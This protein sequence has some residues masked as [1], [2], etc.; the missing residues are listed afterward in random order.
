[1]LQEE[2][3]KRIKDF[4]QK[5]GITQNDL[6]NALYIS[7]QAISKW[8]RG[9]NLPDIVHLPTLANI[10][11]ISIDRLLGHDFEVKK[12]VYGSIFFSDIQGF[13]KLSGVLSPEEVAAFINGHFYKITESV[14]Q[15]NG[16]PIKY[17][18]DAFLA[19]FLGE[20]TEERAIRA[21]LSSKRIISEDYSIGIN[22]GSFYLGAIGHPD[23][24]CT[25]VMGAHVNLASRACWAFRNTKS[26]IAASE[27]SVANLK[28]KLTFGQI[29]TVEFKGEK[30]TIELYEIVDIKE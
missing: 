11:G 25:D 26:K 23:Y 12:E 28:D 14:L 18:G 10:F 4:R 5:L 3:G 17:I 13:V 22:T 2:L 24:S 19:V 6:A 7:S 20:Q 8:E 27:Y 29:E 9:E 16:I 30:N 1:M 15:Y 21:A